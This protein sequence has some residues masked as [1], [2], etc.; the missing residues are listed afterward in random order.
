MNRCCS[1]SAD[2][3]PL[4]QAVSEGRFFQQHQPFADVAA[5]RD[6]SYPNRM[7]IY[8]LP[9]LGEP[10][11]RAEI[12]LYLRELAATDPKKVWRQEREHGLASG[13]DQIFSF[14]FDDNDFDEG[15]VGGSLLDME[16]VRSIDEVKALLNAMLSDLP[17][18]D[19]DAFVNHGL[20]LRLGAKAKDV[21]T[22][23]E[24]RN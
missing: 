3:A 15:A 12:L 16:E 17:N 20:W 4:F 7:T 2:C 9:S 8:N 21:L 24:S 23:F 19:D 22:A 14:F 1:A 6:S 5:R 10:E 11:K 18:G 13:I